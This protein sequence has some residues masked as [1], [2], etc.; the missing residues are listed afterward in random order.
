LAW[1]RKEKPMLAVTT[2]YAALIAVLFA[3]LSLR[4]ALYRMNRQ[5]SIGSD[6]NERF[7]YMVRAHGNCAE[8]AAFGLL[9]LG[10]VEIQG[11]NA[12][13]VHALGAAFLLARL[14]HAGAFSGPRHIRPLRML[15]ASLTFTVLFVLAGLLLWGSFA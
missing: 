15:G 13:V 9:L 4:V 6:G 11:W 1:S 8:Y 5:L 10:L 14:S 7:D 3:A 12:G 2:I